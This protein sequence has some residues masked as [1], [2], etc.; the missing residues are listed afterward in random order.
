AIKPIVDVSS[1]TVEEAGKQR[2]RK[3]A[4][5]FLRDQVFQY[6]EVSNVCV[7][8]GNAPDVEEFLTLVEER[9]P[10][11]EIQQGTIGPVIGTHGGPRVLGVTFLTPGTAG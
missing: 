11:D 2:T 8:S 5:A 1:G 6:P 9:I 3:K 10:R 4:L 7:Y